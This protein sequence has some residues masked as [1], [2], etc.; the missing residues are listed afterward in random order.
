MLL[1]LSSSL[2]RGSRF[3]LY[4]PI[5]LGRRKICEIN[6]TKLLTSL[7]FLELQELLSL[8]YLNSRYG[9]I[10]ITI[11]LNFSKQLLNLSNIYL[12]TERK[13]HSDGNYNINNDCTSFI[14]RINV[15]SRINY[16]VIAII[17][18]VV[19]AMH[20]NSVWIINWWLNS[21]STTIYYTDI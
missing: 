3:N 18:F 4:L 10:M 9:L 16:F 21:I 7:R 13:I 14:C 17:I 11:F 2:K 15:H 8:L 1:T 6:F 19:V 20:I 12:H 5:N